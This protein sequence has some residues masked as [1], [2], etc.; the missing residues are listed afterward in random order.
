VTEDDVDAPE[1]EPAAA[2]AEAVDEAPARRGAFGPW[3]YAAVFGA[4]AVVVVGV[5][6]FGVWAVGRMGDAPALPDGIQFVLPPPG[7]AMMSQDRVGVQTR[8]SWSCTLTIDGIRLPESQYSGVKELGECY[9][10]AGPQ[11]MIE[12]FA[13]GRHQVQATVFPL[14]NP[15]ATQTFSWSFQTQ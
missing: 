7:G 11:K 2:A 14:A 9:F 1:T 8:Q 4:L 15:E 3:G 5:I 10:Q 12:E 13:P 6:G